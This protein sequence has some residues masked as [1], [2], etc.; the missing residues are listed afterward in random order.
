MLPDYNVSP[1]YVELM[2]KDVNFFLIY[3]LRKHPPMCE[4]T[5]GGVKLWAPDFMLSP[6]K[7]EITLGVFVTLIIL[8]GIERMKRG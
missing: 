1:K 6:Y 4:N 8:L 2:S 7:W 3:E 5:I